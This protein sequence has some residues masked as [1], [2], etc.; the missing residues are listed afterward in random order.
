MKK[1]L[2]VI[3][4]LFVAQAGAATDF[5]WQVGLHRSTAEFE[6][7][8]A[9]EEARINFRVGFL[10]KTDFS[11]FFLRSG[12]T[13]TTRHTLHDSA[14]ALLRIRY[15]YLDVPVLAGL[16]ITDQISVYAGAVLGLNVNKKYELNPGPYG[17]MQDVNDLFVLGQVGAN[18]MF[19]DDMGIDVYVEHSVTDMSGDAGGTQNTLKNFFSYGINL[20]KYF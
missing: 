9:S 17:S 16:Q 15:E 3:T 8:N 12:L 2:F 13:F 20:V 7:L 10:T 6:N 5:G 4:M 1:F 14:G 18:Y 19:Q 11:A